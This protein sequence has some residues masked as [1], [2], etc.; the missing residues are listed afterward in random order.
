MI[1]NV[2]NF[3]SVAYA[4]GVISK[5]S[6]LNPQSKRLITMFSSKSFIAVLFFFIEVFDHFELI[7]AYG[8]S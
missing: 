2:F 1:S 4:C 8:V 5:K 7:V 6:L 3:L